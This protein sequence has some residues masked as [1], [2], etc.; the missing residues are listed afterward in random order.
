[1]ILTRRQQF[2]FE[3]GD[4][5]FLAVDAD[6]LVD[7]EEYGGAEQEIVGEAWLDETARAVHQHQDEEQYVGAVGDPE[8]PE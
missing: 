8:G 4:L 6:Q 5:D 1:M 7:G 3:D 2:S